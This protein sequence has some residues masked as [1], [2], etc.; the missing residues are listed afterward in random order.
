[1]TGS[2]EA[3]I[4]GRHRR[5][6]LCYWLAMEDGSEALSAVEVEVLHGPGESEACVVEHGFEGVGCD[7]VGGGGVGRDDDRAPGP[8]EGGGS[9]DGVGADVGID[10]FEEAGGDDEVESAA[11]SGVEVEQILVEELVGEV[12]VLSACPVDGAGACVDSEGVVA[13]HGELVDV[14]AQAAAHDDG[15]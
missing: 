13:S 7:R 5:E 9:G 6:G 3:Q 14:I 10:G 2:G 11:P 12:G 1:V 8:D 4:R 15:A